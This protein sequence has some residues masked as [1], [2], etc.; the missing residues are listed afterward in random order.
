MTKCSKFTL[1]MKIR[2]KFAFFKNRT[3]FYILLKISLKFT[4]AFCSKIGPKISNIL[5]MADEVS[6]SYTWKSQK[7]YYLRIGQSPSCS[8]TYSVTIKKWRFDICFKK[9]PWNEDLCMKVP[10]NV[11]EASGKTCWSKDFQHFGIRDTAHLSTRPTP[12]WIN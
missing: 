11:T 1:F 3:E 9:K 6:I 5:S 7:S 10:K 8:T 12:K 2:P 4:F